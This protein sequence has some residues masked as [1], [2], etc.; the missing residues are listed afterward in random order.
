M[1]DD[2]DKSPTERFDHPLTRVFKAGKTTGDLK[3]PKA[4]EEDAEEV[5]EGGIPPAGEAADK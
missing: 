2:N 5:M 3:R 4:A 1:Q